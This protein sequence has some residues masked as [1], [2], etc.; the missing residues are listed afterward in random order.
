[1]AP[2]VSILVFNFIVFIL[3][4]RV[5]VKKSHGNMN[6]TTKEGKGSKK[7]AGKTLKTLLSLV[8]VML[9]FGLSWLFGALSISGAAHVFQWL[10]IFCATTQGFWLFV[11]FCVIG[12]DAREEWKRLLSCYR[13]QASNNKHAQ[14]VVST[15]GRNKS[16]TTKAST[17][18]SK[19]YSDSGTLKR[20]VGLASMGT[21]PPLESKTSIVEM[22][23]RSPA[24]TSPLHPTIVEQADTSLIIP[25]E[26]VELDET[27]DSQ[28]PPHVLLRLKKEEPSNTNLV[29]SNTA[30]KQPDSEKPKGPDS[31][32]PPQVL[33]RL[34]RSHY[35]L[36]VEDFE[37][38]TA[39]CFSGYTNTQLSDIESM[40]SFEEHFSFQD[41]DDIS[42]IDF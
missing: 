5:L 3:V 11:F 14:S 26:V 12:K 38:T 23:E 24:K 30:T 31:Q 37:S 9:M 36:M 10:F 34:K 35:D 27:P 21:L 39:S 25:N 40:D 16:Y 29:I 22:S 8:S 20:N 15:A 2:L 7:V 4:G 13:Y 17:L 41:Y 28:L 33:F 1:M 6:R 32:L 42:D 18:T 19:Q